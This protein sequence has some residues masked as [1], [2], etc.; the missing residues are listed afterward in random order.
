V[1]RLDLGDLQEVADRGAVGLLVPGAGPTVSGRSALASLS[2]GAVRNSLRGGLPTG[3]ALIAVEHANAVPRDGPAIVLALPRGGEQPN[4]RRYGIAVVAP[5]YEGLLTSSSTRIAGLVSVADVAAAA[6][7][8]EGALGSRPAG[9]PVAALER[10]DRRIRDNGA[11]RLAA[12]LTAGAGVLL[13]A[14]LGKGRAAVLAFGTVLAANLA[15]GALAVSE[16]WAAGLGTAL[17]VAAAVPLAHL[18]RSP[19]A[20]GSALAALIAG[21]LVAMAADP[22]LVALSPLGPTQN[23]R[24]FGLS[25]LLSALLLLP[26]LVATASLGRALGRPAALLVAALA[27]AVTGV[28]RLGADGGGT[29]TLAVG[30]ATLALIASERGRAGLAAAVAAAAAVVAL[31]AVDAGTGGSSHVTRAAGTG[32][33]GVAAALGE[34][35]ALSWARATDRPWVAALVAG[36]AVLLALLAA[37]LVRSGLPR[38]ALALPLAFA[39]A[40]AVSLAVND[41]PL[42]VIAVGLLGFLALRAEAVE[43][44]AGRYE[45]SAS[46]R[47]AKASIS[48][49]PTRAP[50]S[51]R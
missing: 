31:L 24:F 11:A 34:R 12:A 30:F 17:A 10:L 43:E 42:E 20:L 33:G 47:D 49:E 44:A 5:G 51:S 32:S 19:L 21:Y 37:R 1:P 25:N 39:A 7:G 18:L 40:T 15:L 38:A 27:L 36:G 48:S 45:T 26:A 50:S 2:R 14:F 8:G 46:T 13:L 3:D 29:V 6:L 35:A 22:A 23:S 16:A 9:D 41:S 28:S 4:D